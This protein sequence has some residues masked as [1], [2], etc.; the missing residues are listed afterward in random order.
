M[1]A[2]AQSSDTTTTGRVRA[3]GFSLDLKNVVGA[4][5]PRLEGGNPRALGRGCTLRA[6]IAALRGRGE[7]V[8]GM[9][10]GHDTESMEIPLRP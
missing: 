10:P 4:A 1:T 2:W 7:T 6:A 9:L 5:A 3:V 8:V